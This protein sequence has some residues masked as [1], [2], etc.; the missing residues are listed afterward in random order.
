MMLLKQFTDVYE[1]NYPKKLKEKAGNQTDSDIQNYK[2]KFRRIFVNSNV[3]YSI[4]SLKSICQRDLLSRTSFWMKMAHICGLLS[5]LFS[6]EEG[7]FKYFPGYKL[8]ISLSV[9][10]LEAMSRNP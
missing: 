9:I 1:R 4:F 7:E 5:R 2:T 10:I 6:I 8:Y 3:N